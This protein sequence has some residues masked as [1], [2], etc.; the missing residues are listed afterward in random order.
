MSFHFRLKNIWPIVFFNLHF[1]SLSIQLTN[2]GNNFNFLRSWPFRLGIHFFAIC[3]KRFTINR[4]L[5]SRYCSTFNNTPPSPPPSTTPPPSSI[6]PK[7]MSS[8][9][10]SYKLS[11]STTAFVMNLSGDDFHHYYI[12][13]SI[14]ECF[15]GISM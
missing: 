4:S 6:T 2:N 11:I 15:R 8:V 10:E 1:N 13:R 14:Q 3:F 12:L 5:T 9:L 7:N